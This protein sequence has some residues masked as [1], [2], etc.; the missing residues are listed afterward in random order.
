VSR[1]SRA[2]PLLSCASC[3]RADSSVSLP[4]VKFHIGIT[5]GIASGSLC[6]NRRLKIISSAKRSNVS[7]KER[8][9][10]LWI[11]LAVGLVPSVFVM[12]ISYTRQGNRYNI[13]EGFGCAPATYYDVYALLGLYVPGL[14]IG[15][16]SF[17]YGGT[18]DS[19]SQSAVSSRC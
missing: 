15:L 2:Q 9:F 10:A 4:G 16:I 8:R 3:S 13:T 12:A 19:I 6:I 18:L 7:A 17:V 1:R 5:T 14:L 11:D